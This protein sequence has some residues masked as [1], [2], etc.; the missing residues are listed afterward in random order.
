MRKTHYTAS[1]LL[2]L[3]LLSSFVGGCASK[4]VPVMVLRAPLPAPNAGLMLPESQESYLQKWLTLVNGWQA[5][6]SASE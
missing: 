2:L 5:R 4:S 3:A 1:V 6:L